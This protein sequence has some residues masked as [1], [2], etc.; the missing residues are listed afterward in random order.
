MA[1]FAMAIKFLLCFL[2]HEKAS[3]AP[4]QVFWDVMFPSHTS[5]LATKSSDKAMPV[6]TVSP[7]VSV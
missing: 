7:V 2:S 4:M 1:S 6:L 5:M 3:S